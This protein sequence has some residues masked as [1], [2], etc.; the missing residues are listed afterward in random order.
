MCHQTAQ[1]MEQNPK[2]SSQ[3]K[4]TFRLQ[5][6]NVFIAGDTSCIVIRMI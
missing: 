4:A 3:P 5:T 1:D 6:L 2:I